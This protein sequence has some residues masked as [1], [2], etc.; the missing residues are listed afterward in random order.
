[1]LV[2]T[3]TDQVAELLVDEAPALDMTAA[4]HANM[5]KMNL[6]V[7]IQHI[8]PPRRTYAVL[9]NVFRPFYVI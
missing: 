5:D 1:M 7:L 6:V 9:S 3:E 2:Q 4:Y 8:V